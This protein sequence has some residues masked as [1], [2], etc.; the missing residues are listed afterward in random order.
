MHPITTETEPAHIPGRLSLRD[1]ARRL[2]GMI[3]SPRATLLRAVDRPRSL[4]LAM[5]I[6]VVAATF[7]VGFLL[8]RVGRLAALDQAV[9]QLESL[10]ATI[11]DRRYAELRHLQVYRPLISAVT[12]IVGWPMMWMFAAF[13]FRAIGDR[14]HARVPGAGERRVTFAQSLTVVVHASS[15]LAVRAVV[16]AP[17]NY[18]RESLGG[19]T[20]LGV[21]LPVFGETTFAARL[22]GAVDL[23]LVWWVVLIAMGLSILYRTRTLPIARWLLGAYAAGAAALAL[24]QALRGGV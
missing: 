14:F 23:F 17:V 22:F 16:A 11:T 9:R 3:R 24:T 1:A 13:I 2:V 4:D 21:L 18:A 7:S 19:S 15:V 12:I 8:T 20:S 6:V 10:G 5:L